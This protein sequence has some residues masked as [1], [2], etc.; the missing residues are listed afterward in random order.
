MRGEDAVA[1]S[2][3]LTELFA[4]RFGEKTLSSWETIHLTPR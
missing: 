3:A 2:I 4:E 1:A